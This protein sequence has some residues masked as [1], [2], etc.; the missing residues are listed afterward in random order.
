V[1]VKTFLQFLTHKTI[2]SHQ[3]FSTI[4][5]PKNAWWLPGVHY[6]FQL[7][8]HLAIARFFLRFFYLENA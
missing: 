2:S 7:K 5:H 4:S 6:D 3:A 8:K 1:A